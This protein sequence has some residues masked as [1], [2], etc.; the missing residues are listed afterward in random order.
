MITRCGYRCDLCLAYKENINSFEDRKRISD[1]WFKHFGFRIPPEEISCDG[2]LTPDEE[3]PN[4][5]DKSCTVRRC[6]NEKEL[7]NCSMCEV[8]ICKK[9][10][11]RIVDRDDINGVSDEDYQH[12][13]RPY[14][15]KRRLEKIRSTR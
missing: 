14:E 4:L 2:C 6:V 12:F 13:I 10:K 9:L 15:N 7:D 3:E 5:I 11:T 1:G 8:Y